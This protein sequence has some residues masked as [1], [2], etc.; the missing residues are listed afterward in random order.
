MIILQHPNPKLAF[1]VSLIMHH[2][3]SYINLWV[4]LGNLSEETLQ[5]PSVTVRT[6]NGDHDCWRLRAETRIGNSTSLWALFWSTKGSGIQNDLSSQCC[7][8]NWNDCGYFFRY[9]KK[10]EKALSCLT[11]KKKR[12]DTWFC[13]S[14]VKVVTSVPF[15][16][17]MGLVGLNAYR[18]GEKF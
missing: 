7:A 18:S 10:R 4:Q 3:Y 5:P 16:D 13:S 2:I 17:P 11:R 6:G 14:Q 1:V 15:W 8:K 12:Y 9:K